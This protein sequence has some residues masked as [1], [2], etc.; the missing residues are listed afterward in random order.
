MKI[1]ITAFE[2]TD[3]EYVKQNVDYLVS[4]GGPKMPE[5]KSYDSSDPNHLRLVFYDAENQKEDDHPS[6]TDIKKLIS[7]AKSKNHKKTWQFHCKAGKHRST[8]AAAIVY[9]IFYG[10]ENK[11]M[12][13]IKQVREEAD[14]NR[15]MLSLADKIL[16]SKLEDAA[17]KAFK[18]TK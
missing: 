11:T 8:A 6:K 14:P 7:W 16:G 13:K 4:I 15:L 2:D 10:D 3:L 5:P 17:K 18:R 1:V 9:F 12:A